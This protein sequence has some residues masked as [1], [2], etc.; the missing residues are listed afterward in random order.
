M[1]AFACA[2]RSR[3]RV[4]LRCQPVPLRCVAPGFT[5]A[6]AGSAPPCRTSPGRVM[7][8]RGTVHLGL[9]TRPRPRGGRGQ[10]ITRQLPRLGDISPSRV[11]PRR[12]RLPR[13]P[14]T[15][16]GAVPLKGIALPS[17][18]SHRT[19]AASS[20]GASAA[21]SLDTGRDRLK[22][23]PHLAAQARSLAGDRLGRLP[24]EAHGPP[25]GL[26]SRSQPR[27]APMAARFRHNR[28]YTYEN[29]NARQQPTPGSTSG[30]V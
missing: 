2:S 3:Q 26:R 15:V 29:T 30:I 5:S 28:S 19:S 22:V 13:G 11:S 21:A 6:V 1:P 4:P 23:G 7:P 25:G 14:R 27:Q 8:R 18:A 24:G 20:P 10:T 17:R 9:A 16:R 12:H